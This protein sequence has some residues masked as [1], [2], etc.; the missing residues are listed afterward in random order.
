LTVALTI[1]W[2][3]ARYAYARAP[4]DANGLPRWNPLWMPRYSGFAA[5]LWCVVIGGVIAATPT[6]FLRWMMGAAALGLNLWLTLL[7][8]PWF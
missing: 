7:S 4:L 2:A 8:S 1:T 3:A 6:R 5:P